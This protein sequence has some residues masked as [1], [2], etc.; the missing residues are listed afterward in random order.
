MPKVKVLVI[1]A[2]LMQPGV[3]PNNKP[4]RQF[5]STQQNE[6]P[7]TQYVQPVTLQPQI[8]YVLKYRPETRNLRH[9]SYLIFFLGLVI[10]GASSII[11]IAVF[12]SAVFIILGQSLCC[13]TFAAGFFMDAAF[14]KGKADWEH[15]TGQSNSGSTVGMVFDVLFGII[16]IGMAILYW[17][18]D[19]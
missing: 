7:V 8:V 6:S 5:I 18:V 19:I 15:S 1:K 16:A 10:Y 12:D 14:Y 17:V 3:E 9:W 11:G 4:P 2:G 13:F